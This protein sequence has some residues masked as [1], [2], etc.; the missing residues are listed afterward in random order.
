MF[1]LEEKTCNGQAIL[2]W[3]VWWATPVGLYGDLD[4]AIEKVKSIGM[5]PTL[6]I[7]PVPVIITGDSYEPIVRG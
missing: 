7:Q 3:K 2:D 5:D 1:N 4:A 6:V